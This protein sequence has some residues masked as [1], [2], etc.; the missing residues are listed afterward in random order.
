[1]TEDVKLHYRDEISEIQTEGN[2]AVY[3]KEKKLEGQRENLQISGSQL[4][5]GV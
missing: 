1:M 4:G 3:H 2:C 5:V